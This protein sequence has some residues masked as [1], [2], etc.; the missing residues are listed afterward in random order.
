MYTYLQRAS[1]TKILDSLLYQS[2]NVLNL[3]DFFLPCVHAQ[4]T[5]FIS[6]MNTCVYLMKLLD[7]KKKQTPTQIL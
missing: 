5:R 2:K 3:S 6:R 7:L 1:L 4:I